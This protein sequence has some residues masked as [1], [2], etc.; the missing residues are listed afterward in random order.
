MLCVVLERRGAGLDNLV[1]LSAG[2]IGMFFSLVPITAIN[3]FARKWLPQLF[4][5]AVYRGLSYK[6]GD[7]YPVHMLAAVVSLLLIYSC[8]IRCDPNF[9][10]ASMVVLLGKYSLLGYLAQ[11]V[12]IRIIVGCL[13]KPQT[14]VSVL[15]LGVFTSALLVII[16]FAADRIRQ[17]S[18]VMD[19]GYRA[20]FA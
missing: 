12:L 8:A 7:I 19:F 15:G 16:I 6:F 17:K 3:R 18:R 20:I 11:I 13:G 10:V 1:L 4:L 5:Y 9:W 2:L 14:G